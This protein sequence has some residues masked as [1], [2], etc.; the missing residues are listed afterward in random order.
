MS[1]RRSSTSWRTDYRSQPDR[2]A[3]IRVPGLRYRRIR[4]GEEGAMKISGKVLAVTGAGNG[5]GR[6]VALEALRRGA[7]VAAIDISE[8]GL[9]ETRSLAAA[10]ESLSTH[11]VDITDRA[12]VS[13]LP[14]E[15]ASIHGNVDGLIHLAA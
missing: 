5:V 1:A 9:E 10:G 13:A 6:A 8:T 3:A 12:R 4:Y 2:A 7:R 15:L 11:V 14:G